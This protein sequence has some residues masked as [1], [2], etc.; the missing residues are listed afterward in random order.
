MVWSGLNG[1]YIH[2]V[3]VLLEISTQVE[4]LLCPW[5]R[6]V[7]RDR[8]ILVIMDLEADKAAHKAH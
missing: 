2:F 7:S 1:I 6:P 3:N 8:R 4:H 5:A